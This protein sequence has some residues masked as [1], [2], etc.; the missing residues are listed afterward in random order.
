M[1]LAASAG[2]RI[3]PA[4]EKKDEKLAGCRPD[5]CAGRRQAVAGRAA[6]KPRTA[7]LEPLVVLA[8]RGAQP[9]DPRVGEAAARGAAVPRQPVGAPAAARRPAAADAARRQG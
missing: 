9:V 6:E 4:H 7:R 8:P 3:I 2:V 1:L 5:G